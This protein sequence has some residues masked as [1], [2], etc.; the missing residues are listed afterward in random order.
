MG[1]PVNNSKRPLSEDILSVNVVL[2]QKMLSFDPRIQK[3]ACIV[4]NL[5]NLAD[6]IFSKHRCFKEFLSSSLVRFNCVLTIIN[7][8]ISQSKA[9]HEESPST[10]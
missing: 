10:K 6:H 5:F 8:T 1:G 3:L 7:Q 2:I 9:K 4:L